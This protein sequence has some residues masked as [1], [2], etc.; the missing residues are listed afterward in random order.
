MT[1]EERRHENWVA[2]RAACT[3]Q[4]IFDE[5]AEAIE[6]DVERYNALKSERR[7]GR[8]FLCERHD[9][10]SLGVAQVGEGGRPIVGAGFVGLKKGVKIRALRGRGEIWFEIEHKWNPD[11]LTCDLMIGDRVLSVSQISQRILCDLLF[12]HD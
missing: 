12:G 6:R 3:E 4:G 2:L 8:R 11:T 7:P 5:I 1:D 10:S 9:I